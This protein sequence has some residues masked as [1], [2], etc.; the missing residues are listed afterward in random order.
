MGTIA[1]AC[2][3]GS[4]LLVQQHFR[5]VQLRWDGEPM[6]GLLQRFLRKK[7]VNKFRGQV[8]SPCDP[9]CKTVDWALAVWH[10]LNACLARL[11]TPEALLGPKYFLSCPVIP[12][13]AQA[14]VKSLENDLS[15][16]LNLDQRLSLGSD[17]EADLVKELQSMC[18]SKSESDI[19]KIADSRD[20]LRRFDSSGNNPVFS[21]TVNNSRMPVSQKVS[22]PL[23]PE[24]DK[25][26]TSQMCITRL[27]LSKCSLSN[28]G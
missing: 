27:L 11:G 23:P 20:D 16:T 24:W 6:H 3:Q 4:D 9:V 25:E 5:W 22:A 21:A 1:K 2:L 26:L 17:D 28:Q 10:Q 12:G 8:P 13:H 19:S 15:L 14:T 7:V 18:S